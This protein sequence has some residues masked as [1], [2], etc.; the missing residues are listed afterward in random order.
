MQM[1]A[2]HNVSFQW[3]PVSLSDIHKA[4]QHAVK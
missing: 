3:V 4:T 2:L 1:G